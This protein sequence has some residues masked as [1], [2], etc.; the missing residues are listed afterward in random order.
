MQAMVQAP[1]GFAASGRVKKRRV[2]WADNPFS[3][4][5]LKRQDCTRNRP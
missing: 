4:G 1:G 5:S 3:T 2:H